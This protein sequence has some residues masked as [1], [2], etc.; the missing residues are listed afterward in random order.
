MSSFD[1]VVSLGAWCQ[2]S[3]Q[4]KKLGW[5]LQQ[6]C[7]DWLVTPW[8]SMLRIFETDG[9]LF[10]KGASFD[11]N[12]GSFECSEY[13]VLYFHKFPFDDDGKPYFQ[14]AALQNARS[15]LIYKYRKMVERLQSGEVKRVLFVRYGGAAFP[16][17]AW[18][19]YYH[20][21]ENERDGSDLNSLLALLEKKFP[22]IEPRLLYVEQPPYTIFKRG[23]VQLDPRVHVA[24]MPVPLDAQWD[25][26]QHVWAQVLDECSRIWERPSKRNPGFL[27]RLLPLRA[28]SAR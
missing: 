19:Y 28:F 2:V 17:L 16:A 3:Y 6:S 5:P 8:D 11:S 27:K 4:V 26:E 23:V 18:P 1:A 12:S 7:F 10:G 14:E 15:K 25:G 24:T 9:D 21:L 22:R 20:D 13:G